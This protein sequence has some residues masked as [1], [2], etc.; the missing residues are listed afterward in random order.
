MSIRGIIFQKEW[1]QVKLRESQIRGVKLGVSGETGVIHSCWDFIIKAPASI[2]EI[3]MKKLPLHTQKNYNKK[4]ISI[5]TYCG[6]LRKDK[7]LDDDPCLD[8]IDK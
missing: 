5:N 8:A 4:T 6:E 1:D 3:C 7:I 2:L